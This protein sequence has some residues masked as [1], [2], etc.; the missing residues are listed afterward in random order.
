MRASHC[1]RGL[2]LNNQSGGVDDSRGSK[3]SVRESEDVIW[4][5]K[6]FCLTAKRFLSVAFLRCESIVTFF[7]A[8]SRVGVLIPARRNPLRP[9]SSRA[10]VSVFVCAALLLST[11]M[12][13][14]GNNSTQR[15]NHF[16]LS[17]RHSYG[18]KSICLSVHSSAYSIPRDYQ[19]RTKHGNC[20]IGC[21]KA[22]TPT[23]T[24][25]DTWLNAFPV[26]FVRAGGVFH[27]RDIRPRCR[28]PNREY[29]HHN[30]SST[31]CI[32]LPT[33]V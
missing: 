15:C 24:L 30:M 6:T 19:N 25:R 28:P 2:R 27:L 17:P 12:T 13:K 5:S 7:V 14:Y 22:V 32:I 21:K 8:R 10:C 29:R 31:P 9:V 26:G 18:M 20:T 3:F 33:R 23:H 11:S 4:C 16:L 1:M